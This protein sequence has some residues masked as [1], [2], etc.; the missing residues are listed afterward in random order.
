[1]LVDKET[2][3]CK[4]LVDPRVSDKFSLL[5]LY[6]LQTIKQEI[7]KNFTLSLESK[8]EQ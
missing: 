4:I 3:V 2:S 8:R 6:M 1:M 5:K 7:N